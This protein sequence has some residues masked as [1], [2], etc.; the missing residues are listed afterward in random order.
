MISDARV[1][2]LLAQKS[3]TRNLD[4]KKSF[5]W[6]IADNDAKCEL[7]KDILSFS[8]TQDGGVLVFGVEDGTF[9]H[10]GMSD[11]DLASFDTTRI[12]DFLHRYTDPQ[13][14]CEIQRSTIDGLN[15]VLISVPEFKDVP[16]IC[17]KAANS[18]KDPSKVIL[19]LGGIYIRTEK[20][21]SEAVPSAEE[22]RDLMN[23]ALLKRGDQ[24]LN[25]I[26]SLLKGG[27]ASQ[28][29]EIDR[30]A[31]EI[32]AAR[33]YFEDVLPSDPEKNG[34]WEIVAMPQSYVQER[35]ANI[36]SVSKTLTEAEV[37]LRGWDFP[38]RDRDTQ[39]NFTKGYQSHTNFMNH[40]EAHRA[41]Q[42]G[43]FVWRGYYWEDFF[44]ST[45]QHGPSLS[46]VNVIYTVTEFLVFLKRFYERVVPEGAIRFSLEMTDTNGRQLVS[47]TSDNL[48]V[49]GTHICKESLLLMSHDYNVPELRASAEEIAIGLVQKIFEVFN[50]NNPD[51][52][53]IRAYQQRLLSRTL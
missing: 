22:M 17:K 47:T 23:R 28:G 1:R 7:V 32:Q 52:S 29:T 36:T 15:L 53:M 6:D 20:A 3:E 40:I 9:K 46:F 13:T 39:S 8:N 26:Q 43:L 49:L 10:V 42:S 33:A 50:W 45:K 2:E 4:C 18:S 14:S 16:I 31:E 48:W 5:N 51:A 35:L 12:N 34:Y 21:S 44:N 38:H 25:M 19:K 24:L 11:A 37:S 41:Y 27:P 30:Y